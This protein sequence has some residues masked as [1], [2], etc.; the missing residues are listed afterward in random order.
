MFINS[1]EKSD[2]ISEFNLYKINFTN[3]TIL[4]LNEQNNIEIKYENILYVNKKITFPV[5]SINKD[6][7]S[8]YK[9]KFQSILEKIEKLIKDSYLKENAEI[10]LTI[11]LIERNELSSYYTYNA[12]ILSPIRNN[13]N[14]NQKI[15]FEPLLKEYQNKYSNFIS[16]SEH[17]M[18]LQNFDSSFK[19]QLNWKSEISNL[20]NN[21]TKNKNKDAVFVSFNK[22]GIYIADSEV[23]FFL[24]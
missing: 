20:N 4:F 13:K 14:Q 19:F 16:Q 10:I 7:T 3:D 5:N 2:Q 18:E 12:I 8:P 1:N 9:E 17:I 6:L 21:N 22:Q 23:K 15:F 24:I 11:N